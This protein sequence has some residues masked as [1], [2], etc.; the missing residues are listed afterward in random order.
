M[1]KG[2]TLLV[3]PFEIPTYKDEGGSNDK[4]LLRPRSQIHS[5]VPV[6]ACNPMKS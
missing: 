4:L 1:K 6:S 5:V 2:V 3:T